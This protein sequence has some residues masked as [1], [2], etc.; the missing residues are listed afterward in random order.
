MPFWLYRGYLLKAIWPVHLACFIRYPQHPAGFLTAT[1]A[2]V[3]ILISAAAWLER[4]RSPWL[5]VGWLWF[6][7]TLV[8]VI[9]LVQVGDQAMADRYGYF[10][11]IGIFIAITF[12]VA[13][14]ANR[15]DF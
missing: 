11:L 3:L 5:L 2:A 14:W 6:L 12:A 10:P 1:A 4:R 13:K 9:G 8:P 7:G 15:L